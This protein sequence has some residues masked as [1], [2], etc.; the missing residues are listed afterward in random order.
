MLTFGELT[1]SPDR[2]RELGKDDVLIGANAGT[3]VVVR[4]AKARPEATMVF[5]HETIAMMRAERAGEM[6]K[7]KGQIGPKS[8]VLPIR[9][10]DGSFWD[11]ITVGRASTSDIVLDDPATSNVH[12][13]FE[14]NAEDRS[15]NIQD[16]G[17]SNG[18]FVNR[19]PLQPHKLTQLRSGDCVRFGQVVFYYVSHDGLRSLLQK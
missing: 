10:K 8:V 14:L 3:E 2:I 15:A 18:T 19:A 5:Q 6:G 4:E 13:H 16:L 11:Q 9:K 17:S 7:L 12:A 1:Q